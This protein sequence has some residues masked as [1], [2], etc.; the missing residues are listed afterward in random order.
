VSTSHVRQV[1]ELTETADLR[2]ASLREV[3]EQI[4]RLSSDWEL[5][6]H[7]MRCECGHAD[8]IDEIEIPPA[9]YEVVRRFPTRFVINPEHV[10]WSGE[11]I[12][13]ELPGYVVIEKVGPGAATALRTDPRRR[14]G[15]QG[16]AS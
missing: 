10:A 11:R 2:Q 16:V 3:N 15:G 1:P 4:G 12:V 5:T 14:N 7:V 9:E 6:A 13:E 8:C